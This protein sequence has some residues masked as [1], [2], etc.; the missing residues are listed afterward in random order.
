MTSADPV[1]PHSSVRCLVFLPYTAPPQYLPLS[2][3][4]K[5]SPCQPQVTVGGGP[6]GVRKTRLGDPMRPWGR[7]VRFN[8]A[9]PTCTWL[10]NI[11]K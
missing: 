4:E 9:T 7:Q 6:Q 2:A 10:F 8:S 1:Q 11:L 3:A 5:V